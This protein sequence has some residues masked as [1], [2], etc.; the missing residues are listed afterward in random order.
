MVA[1]FQLFSN[2][3][4]LHDLQNQKPLKSQNPKPQS[5]KTHTKLMNWRLKSEV[6]P[7]IFPAKTKQITIATHADPKTEPQ[8]DSHHKLKT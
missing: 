2:R 8:K 3:H 4:E 7:K 5:L 1:C 6:N